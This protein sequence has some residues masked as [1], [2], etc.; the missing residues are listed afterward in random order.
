MTLGRLPDA[1]SD[2]RQAITHADQSGDAFLRFSIRT[3]AADALHQS[4]QR[5]EAGTLFVEAEAMQQ[6]DQPQFDLLYSLQGF[7]YCDWLL[8]PAEQAAW[9]H[10]LHQPRSNL[11]S[12][13]SDGLA[14]VERRGNK[15]FE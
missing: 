8:A 5:M 3:T 10:V 7:R 12:Q 11:K 1:V 13:L 9:Q 14:D 15:M 2:A 6:K 4:G